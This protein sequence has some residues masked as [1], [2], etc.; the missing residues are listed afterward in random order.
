MQKVRVEVKS[1]KL[2]VG[3]VN[4]MRPGDRTLEIETGNS[5]II[6][7]ESETKSMACFIELILGISMFS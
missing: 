4:L 3:S 1:E 2:K 7:L 5:R 6:I